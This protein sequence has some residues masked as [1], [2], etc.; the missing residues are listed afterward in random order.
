MGMAPGYGCWRKPFAIVVSTSIVLLAAA[1]AQASWP[2]A[3][4][5]AKRQGTAT[6]TANIVSPVPFWRTYLG[7]AIGAG[8]L[9]TTDVN[10][11]GVADAILATS[12]QIVA[13]GADD[14]VFWKT[15]PRGV[16]SLA[17]LGDLDGDGSADIVAYSGDHV[18]VVSA[19][20]GA[21]EWAEP[22]GEM[23]TIGSVRVGDV[24]GDGRPDV[25]VTE[26]GCCGVGSGNPGFIWTFGKGFSSASSVGTLPVFSCGTYASVTLVDATGTGPLEILVADYT[27]FA[28]L[29]GAAKILAQTGNIGTWTSVNQCIAANLDGAPG[30]EMVCLLNSSDAPA[31]NQRVVTVLHYDT[32][33]SP[34]TLALLW[35]KVLAPDS[36]GDLK[37]VDPVQDLDGDGKQE[38]VVSALDPSLGWQT[39]IFDALSGTEYTPAIGGQQIVAGTAAM[40]SSG[41][42]LVLTAGNGADTLTAWTF[43]KTP[44]SGVTQAW[45]IPNEAL[46]TYSRPDL[47]SVCSL[48]L[49]PVALDLDGDKLDDVVTEPSSGGAVDGYSAPGGSPK[50][51]GSFALPPSTSPLYAWVLPGIST[52]APQVGLARTDGILNLLDGKLQPASLPSS[53]ARAVAIGTGGYY[54]TGAWREMARAPRVMSFDGGPSESV[55]VD[56]SREALLRFDAASASFAV[57][58]VSSWAVTHTYAPTI[59][60]GLDGAHPGIA[61][62][63]LQEPVTATPQYRARALR[64]DGSVLWDVSIGT[65]PLTDLAPGT[66]NTDATP[67]VVFQ[68]GAPTDPNLWT[69]ALSGADGTTL[70]TSSPVAP[71][72]G[73]QD[74]GV[75]VGNFDTDALD[76]VFFQGGATIAL[77]GADGTQLAKG[78]SPAAYYLPQLYDTNGDG[79]DEVILNAGNGPV[80]LYSHDLQSAL[81]TSP[82]QDRPYPYGAVAQCGTSP[83][84]PM[85]VEGSW[86][87]PA[88]IKVTPLAGASLGAFKTVVLA[89]GALYPDEGTAKSN[90]A[91]LGQLTS[92]NVHSNLTGKGHPSAAI[93]SADGWLYVFD[94][95]AMTLDFAMNLGAS[96]GESVFGD[97][98]GD[99]VDEILVTAADGYLYDIRNEDVPAPAY[100]W[101][102]DPD[103][104]I[105]DHDVDSVVTQDK[106]SAV[107]APV[108]G[109][110]GYAVT[111]VTGAGK[112]ISNP[113]WKEVGS[114][115]TA[116]LTGLALQDGGR[117]FFA[118]HALRGTQQSVDTLSNGVT[119]HLVAGADAGAEAGPGGADASVGDASFPDSGQGSDA[120]ANPSN[121]HGGNGNGCGCRVGADPSPKASALALLLMVAVTA[122]AR[123]RRRLA[124]KASPT[125][126]LCP[127]SSRL[128]R[129]LTR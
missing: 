105:T 49:A 31:T 114:V 106:L 89:G 39:R 67:D 62:L 112:P 60:P 77:S 72:A 74:V 1:A 76:D 33:T 28:L 123:A 81:W 65:Q 22:D 75:S 126:E 122:V 96:V 71:G 54:A 93:G 32:S 41:G 15:Q 98:N 88:R 117:Y 13:K 82:D 86:Q 5:D 30:N 59:V 44:Q 63:A 57:P 103:H 97:T 102:T 110:T 99:G 100:V 7:G 95:C 47:F 24:T 20:T 45:Q 94:P 64:A 6:G 43:A 46:L 90:G 11:D 35:T 119:V 111:V 109:A 3:R 69:V 48:S 38:L 9:L 128:G 4:H 58:P 116:S 14:T 16:A 118:V 23:G 129:R 27:H 50:A 12:G 66:F 40:A 55:V 92:A 84:I 37:W 53:P 18:Y 91:F 25:V 29:D 34:A 36:G 42:R 101:D 120:G 121:P 19:K 51:V 70:W 108:A 61:C 78:G 26:C 8:Q 17:G 2:M 127:R 113:V 107:W 79:S 104:G 52:P 85:L 80:N 125:R 87:N 21:I 10:G 68:W 115:T 56:D 73:K 124:G 83:S